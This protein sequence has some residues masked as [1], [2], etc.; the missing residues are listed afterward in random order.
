MMKKCKFCGVDITPETVMGISFEEGYCDKLHRK[1][2]EK[3]L[4][5]EGKLE[6]LPQRE[7][8]NVMVD[9]KM[10]DSRGELV[11]FPKSGGYYDRALQ[12]QFNTKK[13]KI[14]YMNDNNLAME[15]NDDKSTTDPAAGDNRRNKP[16]Y[17]I[18]K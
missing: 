2:H 4:I 8:L 11:W 9:T 17:S 12:K 3:I 6:G 1:D 13:E 10:R 5:K 14:K 18:P 15:G 7:G 16:I